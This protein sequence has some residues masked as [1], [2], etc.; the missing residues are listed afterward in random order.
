MLIRMTSSIKNAR[1]VQHSQLLM[2]AMNAIPKNVLN[3][4]TQVRYFILII[5][6][7]LFI[8]MIANGDLIN[9]KNVIM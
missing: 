6:R 1:V 5:A 2:H 3:A 7:A 4:R 9:N 8:A